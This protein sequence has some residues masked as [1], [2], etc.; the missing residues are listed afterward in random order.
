MA[1]GLWHFCQSISAVGFT[2]VEATNVTLVQSVTERVTLLLMP[3]SKYLTNRFV[4]AITVATILLSAQSCLLN[5]FSQKP[6]FIVKGKKIYGPDGKEFIAK[7]VNIN[8]SNWVWPREMTQDADLIAKCWKFNL[9]RV[10]SLVLPHKGPKWSDNNNLDKLVTEFTKRKVVVMFT[11]HDRTGEYFEGSDLKK[12]VKWHKDLAQKYKDNPYV[13]FDVMNEPGAF[14]PPNRTKWLNLHRQVIK[15][16]R[17]EAGAS[18]VIMV[19]GT[20][21]GQDTG[22]WDTKPVETVNS[23]ILQDG[24]NLIKF[25]GKTYNNIVFSIHTYDQW[26][27]GDSRLANYFDR[28][29]AKNLALVI[30]EYGIRNGNQDTTK[31]VDSM[32]KTAVSRRIGRVAWHWFGGDDNDLTTTENGGGW[33]VNNCTNPTNLTWLGK[34]VWSDTHSRTPQK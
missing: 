8:G 22:T 15:A 11:V 29:L 30:G 3:I 18:N 19:E 6:S 9:V 24:N 1:C 34:K 31:S 27:Y 12:L 32:F 5:A 20:A 21:W 14:P 28:V 25:N 10:N 7:G 2:Q 4:S 16:I 23:A 13:W 33:H 26:K 17:D